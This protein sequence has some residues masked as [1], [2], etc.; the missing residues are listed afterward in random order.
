MGGRGPRFFKRWKFLP[1]ELKRLILLHVDLVTTL[2]AALRATHEMRMIC[3]DCH[4]Q[5]EWLRSHESEHIDVLIMLGISTL[6]RALGNICDRRH[7]PMFLVHWLRPSLVLA[8][9]I[10]LHGV[11]REALMRQALRYHTCDA[12]WTLRRDES[13]LEVFQSA[14]R[15]RCRACVRKLHETD[16]RMSFYAKDWTDSY[17]WRSNSLTPFVLESM[18]MFVHNWTKDD[19]A[20][21]LDKALHGC[22][23]EDCLSILVREYNASI[24]KPQEEGF[25]SQ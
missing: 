6:D 9:W 8:P 22:L 2:N 1:F 23:D 10:D 20:R 24:P 17:N 3:Q 19:L 25:Y 4:F 15:T 16:P 5:V 12:I 11:Q 21:V 13:A 18:F 7:R 14:V